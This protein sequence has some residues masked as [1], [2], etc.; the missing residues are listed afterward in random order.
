M[1][2]HFCLVLVTFR[3]QREQFPV[4]GLLPVFHFLR[5]SDVSRLQVNAPSQESFGESSSSPVPLQQ[6]FS[7]CG[8]LPARTLA[9]VSTHLIPSLMPSSMGFLYSWLKKHQLHNGG[10][11]LIM[12][13]ILHVH[14]KKFTCFR[15]LLNKLCSLSCPESPRKQSFY[16]LLHDQ[17]AIKCFVYYKLQSISHLHQIDILSYHLASVPIHINNKVHILFLLEGIYFPGFLY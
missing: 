13:K 2:F 6:N 4:S 7:Q 15:H 11:F 12:W 8:G 1:N 17:I 9:Q 14:G 10:N 3:K 5:N 16:A